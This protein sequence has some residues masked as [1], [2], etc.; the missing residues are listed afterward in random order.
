[1][2]KKL[3]EVSEESTRQIAELKENLKVAQR[4]NKSYEETLV[5]NTSDYKDMQSKQRE[6]VA[7]HDRI[8]KEIAEKLEE[9]AALK[10]ENNRL[11]GTVRRGLFFL[12]LL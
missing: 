4:K 2:Q 1:M 12:K 11:Q 7:E 9:N 6:F 8:Q 10:K 3:H 5:A